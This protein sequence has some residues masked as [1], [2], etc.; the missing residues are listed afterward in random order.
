VNVSGSITYS[1]TGALAAEAPTVSDSAD[2]AT[3]AMTFNSTTQLIAGTITQTGS[4]AVVSRFSVSAAGTG[5]VTYG[6]GTT[7]QIVNW[8]VRS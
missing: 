1:G 5:T 4:G 7:A 8:V 2:G 3:V 6:N